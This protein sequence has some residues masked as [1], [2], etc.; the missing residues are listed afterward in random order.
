MFN[1]NKLFAL[2]VKNKTQ[3]AVSKNII[4]VP[5]YITFIL[6]YYFE[7]IVEFFNTGL[8]TGLQREHEM[9]HI[10]VHM[11]TAKRICLY[12]SQLP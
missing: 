7:V 5:Y 6:F 8:W 4:F 3:V 9:K 2:H 1:N 12:S 10:H 11:Q